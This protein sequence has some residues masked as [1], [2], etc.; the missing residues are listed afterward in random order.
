MTNETKH[1]PTPWHR[2][3]DYIVS[4]DEIAVAEITNPCLA[5]QTEDANAAFIVRAVNAHEALVRAL[6]ELIEAAEEDGRPDRPCVR[7]ARAALALA[8]GKE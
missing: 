5:S 7:V 4:E 3:G 6:R 8:E 2:A 1:T